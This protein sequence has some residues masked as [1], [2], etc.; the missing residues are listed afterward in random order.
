VVNL[1]M[2]SNSFRRRFDTAGPF[3][4]VVG[5]LVLFGALSNQMRN[6][7]TDDLCA[8]FGVANNSLRWRL[9]MN[10]VTG[11]VRQA[12]GPHHD[13]SGV[14]C[15][16]ARRQCHR[17]GRSAQKTYPAAFAD[18]ARLVGQHADGFGAFEY[19]E[20]RTCAGGVV[21]CDMQLRVCPAS[22]DHRLQPGLFGRVVRYGDRRMCRQVLRR[23][24][25][26]AHMG[27]QVNDFQ[28]TI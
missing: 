23:H 17:V 15:V 12:F 5:P 24:F 4:A 18:L 1:K 19:L 8:L 11:S 10:V 6:F 16:L 26:T 22:L 20:P 25:E 21:R 13:R 7:I 28:T 27:R 9:Q 2:V 14:T 3:V